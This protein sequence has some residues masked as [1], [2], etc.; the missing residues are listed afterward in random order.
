MQGVLQDHR[1]LEGEYDDQGKQQPR[2]RDP[3]KL[4]DELVGEPGLAM[5]RDEDA[6]GEHSGRQ[7]N[8]HEEHD[9]K[10]Q[11][12]PGNDNPADS[13]EEGHN[14]GKGREYDEIV[15]GSLHNRVRGVS[16][17]KVTPDKDHGG[18]GRR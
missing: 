12:S 15:G 1:S 5:A 7:G 16:L 8:Y 9:R 17:R 4:R 13:E 6:T 2:Y 10:N 18:T 11:R 3:G 14:R